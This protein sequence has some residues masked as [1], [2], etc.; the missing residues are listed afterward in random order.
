M[1]RTPLQWA[2]HQGHLEIALALV[3]AGAHVQIGDMVRG[4]EWGVLHVCT[5]LGLC[6]R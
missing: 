5:A 4:V 2:A 1:G 6:G 3:A